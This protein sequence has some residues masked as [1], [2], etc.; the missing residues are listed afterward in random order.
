MMDAG[1]NQEQQRTEKKEMA[2]LGIVQAIARARRLGIDVEAL[3]QA[4]EPLVRA[5]LGGAQ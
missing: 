1:Q 5:I 3:R 4:A 2:V